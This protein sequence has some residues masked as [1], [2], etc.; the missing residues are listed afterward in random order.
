ME[1]APHPPTARVSDADRERAAQRLRLAVDD[2]SLT[3]LEYDERLRDAYAARTVGD[4]AP[5]TADLPAPRTAAPTTVARVAPAGPW[6]LWLVVSVVL[7]TVWALT[8]VAA[9]H[10]LFFWPVFPIGFWALSLGGG[11]SC[12][13]RR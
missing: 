2:G 6:R 10:A 7:V 5:L 9:G 13:R 12:G 8:S 4:L 11:S 1:T 3:L